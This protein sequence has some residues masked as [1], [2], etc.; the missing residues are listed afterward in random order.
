MEQEEVDKARTRQRVPVFT[1]A[2]I[3]RFQND[4]DCVAAETDL[5][6]AVIKRL[7][8]GEQDTVLASCT[9]HLA[10]PHADPGLPCPASFLSCLDCENAR[11]LPHQLPVQLAAA[12]RIAALRPHLDPVVWDTRLRPRL[13]QLEEIVNTYTAAEREQARREV[14]SRQQQMIDEFL[15]G[16][17]DLR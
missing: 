14:T 6:V 12:E 16:R 15:E 3:A 1:T 2:F 9:D 13:D 10:S 11:A 5:D 4:P 17:W 8:V 7:L